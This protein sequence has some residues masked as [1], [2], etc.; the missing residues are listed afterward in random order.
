VV[1]F[2]F[3]GKVALDEIELFLQR[4]ASQGE[5]SANVS[6]WKRDIWNCET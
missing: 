6:E 3:E 2:F 4:I 1:E 5:V